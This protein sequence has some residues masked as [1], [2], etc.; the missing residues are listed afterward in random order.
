[1]ESDEVRVGVYVC[2][3]G[4]NIAG[5]VDCPDVAAVSADLPGVVVSKDYRYMCSDPGQAMIRNDIAE[6]N[7]NRVVVAAC[8]PRMH[9]PTFR[10][11]VETGGINPFLFEMAN[12]REFDSWCHSGM[13]EEATEKAKDLVAMAVAKARYLAP[14]D[15][16]KV[17]VT[18]SSLVI[19]GGVAGIHTALDLADMGHQ[20][21][22]VERSS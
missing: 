6:H 4:L 8:S 20:V 17:P 3:C 15:P 9:E 18:P 14:L 16:L 11:C 22:L 12:I 5:V 7:L 13:P 2:H 1:M 10:K 21:Y 19:G